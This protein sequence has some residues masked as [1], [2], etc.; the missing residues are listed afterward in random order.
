MHKQSLTQQIW[1][2]TWTDGQTKADSHQG[3]GKPQQNLDV[4]PHPKGVITI[5]GNRKLN[6]AVKTPTSQLPRVI[7]RSLNMTLELKPN[8]S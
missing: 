3:D 7:Y 8:N 2:Q 5:V 4:P 1:I 6:I